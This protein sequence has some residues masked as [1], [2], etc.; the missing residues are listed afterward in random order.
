[1]KSRTLLAI[2]VSGSI[3]LMPLL[4]GMPDKSG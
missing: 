3:S 1:M 2:A 4:N